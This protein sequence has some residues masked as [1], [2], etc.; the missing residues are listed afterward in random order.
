MAHRKV[1][2]PRPLLPWTGWNWQDGRRVHRG[3]LPATGGERATLGRRLYLVRRRGTTG[4]DGAG[5]ASSLCAQLA[6]Q[7]ATQLPP[8]LLKL[9]QQMVALD[10]DRRLDID[11]VMLTAMALCDGA[12][13]RVFV[14]VDALDEVV[15]AG[16][17]AILL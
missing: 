10:A 3:Q 2:E 9:Y 15:L 6:A 7:R 12:F 11:N 1:A 17:R 16:E 14:C 13:D 5:T 4:A 8:L